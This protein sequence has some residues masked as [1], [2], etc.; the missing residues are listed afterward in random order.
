[1]RALLLLAIT[2]AISVVHPLVLIGVPFVLMM[3][4]TGLQR[5][6]AFGLTLLVAVLVVASMDGTP[7]GYV[8]RAWALL[9]GGGF[10]VLTLVRPAMRFIARA[11]GA[12]AVAMAAAGALVVGQGRWVVLDWLMEDRMRQGVAAALDMLRQIRGGEGLPP[13]VVAAVQETVRLQATVFPAV[14][15]LASLSALGVAWWSYVRLTTGRDHGLRP[16][17][18]FRFNDHL[19]WVFIGGLALTVLQWGGELARVG[20][21]AVVFMGALYAVRGA[22]VVMFLSGGGLSA[23]SYMLVA[24]GLV[25][26]PPLVM[27]GALVIGLGDTWFDVRGRAAARA[28]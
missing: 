17:R 3:L 9:V 2:L 1:M 16:L 8:E 24:A 25:F 5:P 7:F 21:N 26:M 28:A 6:A 20:T 14:L 4:V 23:L 15:A 10:T 18:E 13:S 11:L 27:A 12:V 19:V 22:A